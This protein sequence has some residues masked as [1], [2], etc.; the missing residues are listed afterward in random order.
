MG[1]SDCVCQR[2]VSSRW[3]A[4]L[5]FY[6]SFPT[7]G[8]MQQGG[9]FSKCLH[10]TP[11]SALC[12]HSKVSADQRSSGCLLPS[13][14]LASLHI[15]PAK[16]SND[17]I[18]P[19]RL[20]TDCGRAVQ[21]GPQERSEHVKESKGNLRTKTRLSS[22]ESISWMTMSGGAASAA[23]PLPPLPRPV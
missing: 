11:P 18:F 9:P 7:R 4:T 8:V 17:Y 21:S 10:R 2:A 16:L 6:S 22:W 3:Q 13:T 23:S 20:S 19:A 12:T 15:L 14:T 5:S 1:G